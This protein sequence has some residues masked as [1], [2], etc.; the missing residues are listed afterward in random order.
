[1]RYLLLACCLLV[2]CESATDE[3]FTAL[4]DWPATEREA[5]LAE[6]LPHGVMWEYVQ[7]DTV[8]RFYYRS[9]DD[10]MCAVVDGEVHPCYEYHVGEDDHH[11]PYPECTI[12][13]TKHFTEDEADVESMD[14]NIGNRLGMAPRYAIFVNLPS[15]P[16]G[17]PSNET[18]ASTATDV[19]EQ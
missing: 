9:S 4:T 7:W 14:Y 3:S 1:M 5:V 17:E 8:F 6:S 11:Y 18:D 10:F 2:A 13:Y 12:S 15:W 19:V 16:C